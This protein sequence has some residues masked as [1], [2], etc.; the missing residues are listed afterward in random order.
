MAQWVGWF[1][2]GH[3]YI[4]A[5]L[6]SS[7]RCLPKLQIEVPESWHGK[8]SKSAEPFNQKQKAHYFFLVTFWNWNLQFF[9]WTSFSYFVLQFE[10]FHVYLFQDT[11]C[12]K[13]M[14]FRKW[15]VFPNHPF[16]IGFSILF[17]IHFGGLFT[18]IILETSLNF[19]KNKTGWWFQ[20][21]FLF[22]PQLG[23]D[24]HFD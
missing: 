8:S 16:P 17:T 4:L 19:P 10:G 22:S 2:I 18:P 1:T 24:S 6:E 12:S 7:H 21:Y 9:F 14:D 13:W 23:E 5:W 15:W 20:K 11:L 3:M